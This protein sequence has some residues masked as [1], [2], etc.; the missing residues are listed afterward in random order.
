MNERRAI[1]ELDEEA[2]R[3]RDP[4]L[5]RLRCDEVNESCPVEPGLA[6]ACRQCAAVIYGL[7]V[8]DKDAKRE[9][10]LLEEATD[11]WKYG[12]GR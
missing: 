12:Q 4:F 6:Y 2:A 9:T 1:D 7:V 5:H 11:I 3:R 10:R 8:S